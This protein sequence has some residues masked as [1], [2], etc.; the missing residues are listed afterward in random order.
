MNSLARFRLY[1]S[2]I[3]LIF[4]SHPLFA[5]EAN[6]TFVYQNGPNGQSLQLIA[7]ADDD[8]DGIDNALELNGYTYDPIGGLQPWSGDSTVTYYITDPRRWS[9]DGAVGR[10]SLG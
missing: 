3:V 9:T 1:V 6:N 2:T 5:Q 10:G 7:N 4:I 8:G